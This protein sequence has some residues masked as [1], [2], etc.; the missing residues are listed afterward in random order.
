MMER[1]RRVWSRPELSSPSPPRLQ[2]LTRVGGALWPHLD[3][4]S[5]ALPSDWSK[6]HTL[7]ELSGEEVSNSG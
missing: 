4:S 1:R 2:N 6:I 7:R 3:L 5:L